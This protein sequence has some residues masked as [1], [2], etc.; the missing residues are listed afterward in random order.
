[1]DMWSRTKMLKMLSGA[2]MMLRGEFYVYLMI[3]VVSFTGCYRFY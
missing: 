2:V 1:M 3:D